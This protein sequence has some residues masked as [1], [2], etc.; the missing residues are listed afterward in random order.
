[1]TN[2]KNIKN[3]KIK[4]TINMILLIMVETIIVKKTKAITM[5]KT[6]IELVIR[7]II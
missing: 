4:P 7:I 5:L 6:V 2:Q 3:I 1:M